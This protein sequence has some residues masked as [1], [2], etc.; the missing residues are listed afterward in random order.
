MRLLLLLLV[1]FLANANKY[2]Q[3]KIYSALDEVKTRLGQVYYC[4]FGDASEWV[5][6]VDLY[7][8]EM[9]VAV[10]GK[11]DEIRPLKEIEISKSSVFFKTPPG[12]GEGPKSDITNWRRW[13][14]DRVNNKGSYSFRPNDAW[15]YVDDVDCSNKIP[16]VV[17][18]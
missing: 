1:S 3:S 17:K 5:G 2:D 14:I 11:V 18:K 4:H 9:V 8:E 13:V 16:S 15:L 10:E 7:S 6:K 12:F